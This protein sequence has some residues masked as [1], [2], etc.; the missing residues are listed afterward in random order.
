MVFIMK[1]ILRQVVQRS[2]IMPLLAGVL[3]FGVCCGFATGHVYAAETGGEG[4]YQYKQDTISQ[5]GIEKMAVTQAQSNT[6]SHARNAEQVLMRRD[7]NPT[8]D[9]ISDTPI[10]SPPL[11]LSPPITEVQTN[12]YT[13]P[14]FHPQKTNLVITQLPR[15]HLG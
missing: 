4:Y 7:I 2:F 6:C 12:F 10:L 15:S 9:N 3:L 11:F 5:G 14:Y 1:L 13:Q 8:K